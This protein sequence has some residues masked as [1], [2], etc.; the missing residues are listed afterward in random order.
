M[1]AQAFH[2]GRWSTGT[3][4]ALERLGQLGLAIRRD[5]SLAPFTTYRVGG[6]A[7]GVLSVT[8]VAELEAVRTIAADTDLAM[9]VVGNGSNLLV[10]DRGFDGL[11]LHLTDAFQEIS[12]GETGFEETGSREG[13]V[14]GETATEGLVSVRLGATTLL[15]VAARATVRAGLGGFEWAVGVPGSVGGAVFM[16]AGGH[17]SDIAASLT[18]CSVF[19][20]RTGGPTEWTASDLAF[21]YRHSALGPDD[22]VLY[23]E[24]AL[25]RADRSASEAMLTEIVRWRREH[26]PGGSNAGSVFANPDGVSAGRLIDQAGLKGFR[27]G[28]ASVSTKHAN[29]IQADPDGAADDVHRVLRYVQRVVLERTGIALRTE[30]RL[31]GFDDDQPL[32]AER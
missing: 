12:F 18:R 7:A 5:D 1:T 8:S 30:N 21:E 4:D 26:Q 22:L 10:A 15:P 11:A 9:L 29:F 2:A 24:L 20:L 6:P 28:T 19:N 13:A 14:G 17:G 25:E 23:A 16:N 31:I 3:K 27:I 32:D